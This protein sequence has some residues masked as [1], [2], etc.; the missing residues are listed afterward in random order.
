LKRIKL[1]KRYRKVDKD[2]KLS[3][4][5]PFGVF[6]SSQADQKLIEDAVKL[7]ED[8]IK[9]HQEKIKEERKREDNGNERLELQEKLAQLDIEIN[10]W[11]TQSLE[12]TEA[13]RKLETDVKSNENKE[14]DVRRQRDEI[15]KL[16]AEK[17]NTVY[18]L[19]NSKTSTLSVYHKNMPAVMV[20]IQRRKKEFK[21]MPIGPLG[22]RVKIL[23]SKEQW[24][25]ICENIFGRT[26]NGFL[27]TN[28]ED[29]RVLQT[30]LDKKDW[31]YIVVGC[32]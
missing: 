5:I 10:E 11:T 26:L 17:K 13:A 20:E 19:K 8:N 9:D 2:F 18:E 3:S 4:Y 25:D 1:L 30:I 29:L 31:Y 16:L 27:V 22:V 6:S 23:E 21:E 24:A 15:R 7:C 12:I 14:K 28:Y 32:N